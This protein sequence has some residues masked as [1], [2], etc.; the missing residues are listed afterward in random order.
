MTAPPIR[1][2]TP[3]RVATADLPAMA[4]APVCPLA[5]RA[6]W[7]A[8]L[9]QEWRTAFPPPRITTIS[10]LRAAEARAW[11]AGSDCAEICTLIGIDPDFVGRVLARACA[12]LARGTFVHIPPIS[13][14]VA[15]APTRLAVHAKHKQFE[16]V[17]A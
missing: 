4:Q 8:V 15:Q 6:L 7:V 3:P 9:A 13:R 1:A 17:A 5:C 16:R 10:D 12:D 11:L 2:Y 14:Q